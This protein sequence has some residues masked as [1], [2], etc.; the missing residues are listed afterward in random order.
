MKERAEDENRA[1]I[2]DIQKYSLHDGP[3]IRTLVFFKG[4]PLTCLWCCNPES[5]LAAQEVEFRG[6]LCVG[7]GACV[8]A[9]PRKAV[10]ESVLPDQTGD[11]LVTQAAVQPL[12]R[13]PDLLPGHR[14]DRTACDGCGACAAVC[15]EGA[16]RLIGRWA[17]VP[18]VMAEV[19]KDSG[20]YRRSG[21]GVTLSGGEPLIWADFCGELLRA[22]YD[23]NIHTAVETTGCVPEEDLERV[24]EWV[25]LFLYDIKSMDTARHE[26][27]TGAP[28]GQIQR[29]IRRL[30]REGKNVVMRI[31]LIPGADGNFRRDELERM[32]ALADELGIGEVDVMPYHDLGR[33][34][35]ERLGRPYRL[36]GLPPLKFAGDLDRQLETVQ[37][38]FQRFGRIAV[39]TGG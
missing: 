28:N 2:F 38:I 34:K 8:R 24:L 5:Q 9:C 27:L 29:N 4:C 18:E 6:D 26:A 1:L 16:L 15:P 31:P 23:A 19:R 37:D 25:D 13:P 10:R 22:C 11:R 21:G 3:G 17:S 35:Y 14:I 20:Y 30:R 32:L 36:D 33:V 39:F 7:C 12:G